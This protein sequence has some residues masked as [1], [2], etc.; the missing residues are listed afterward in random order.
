MVGRGKRGNRLYCVLL[1]HLKLAAVQGSGRT[2]SVPTRR[3]CVIS[4]QIRQRP[5]GPGPCR[6]TNTRTLY[7][8]IPGIASQSG[9]GPAASSHASSGT[10]CSPTR[11]PPWMDTQAG[12]TR[13]GVGVSAWTAGP[14][15]DHAWDGSGLPSSRIFMTRCLAISLRRSPS[16]TQDSGIGTGWQPHGQESRGL[17][18]GVSDRCKMALRADPIERVVQGGKQGRNSHVR[19]SSRGRFTNMHTRARSFAVLLGL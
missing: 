9:R 7:V 8:R 10:G 18:F 1:C 14:L 3:Y 15:P 12:H 17:R 6:S 11:A 13:G 2:H 4:S 5:W 19:R 16:P